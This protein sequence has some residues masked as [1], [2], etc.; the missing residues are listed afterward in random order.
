MNAV[1]NGVTGN[2]HNLRADWRDA[3]LRTWPEILGE[4]GYYTAGIGKMVHHFAFRYAR[5][6]NDRWGRRG[7]LFGDR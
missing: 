6:L 1:R 7:H 5:W 3:G 4:N 2:L